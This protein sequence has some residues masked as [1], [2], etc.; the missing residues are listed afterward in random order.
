[1]TTDVRVAATSETDS[2]VVVPARW[3]RFLRRCLGLPPGRYVFVVSVYS[4]A[5]DW[6]VL[7]IGKVES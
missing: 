5:T 7:S 3:L 1:M 2:V 4:T 6:S